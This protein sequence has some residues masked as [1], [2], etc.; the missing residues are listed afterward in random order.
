MVGTSPRLRVDS[1]RGTL[2]PR[3]VILTVST[4]MLTS[5]KLEFT[6]ALPKRQR[7]AADKLSL[8]SYDHIALELPGNP[9]GL[10]RDE[11]VFEQAHDERTAAL[12][13]NVSGTGLHLVEVAGA[14]GRGLSAQGAPAMIDF[15]REWL[16]GLFGSG[17]KDKI[18]RTHATR[19]NAHP[20]ALGAMSA[21]A[22]G[23]AQAR[24]VLLEPLDGRVWFAG[25]A[26]HE[27][28]WGTVAGA[29]KSGERAAAAVLRH[30][31]ARQKREPEKPRRRSRRH[32]RRRRH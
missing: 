5:G 19:W 22:P 12:L 18:K 23:A 8:G 4:N 21:P 15:A 17:I 1:P 26:L 20:W 6:P 13:A 3:A 25:E 11:L 9:L 2:F 29:W 28:K 14:F 30:I 10:L 31:G 7:D 16:G 27:T 24:A 32:R